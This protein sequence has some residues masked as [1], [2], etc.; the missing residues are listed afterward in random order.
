VGVI[1]CRGAAGARAAGHYKKCGGGILCGTA[2][3]ARRGFET[4]VGAGIKGK[5]GVKRWMVES[6]L[7]HVL[8]RISDQPRGT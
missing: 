2:N 1:V 8:G 6:V 4:R 7:E 5:S 3:I